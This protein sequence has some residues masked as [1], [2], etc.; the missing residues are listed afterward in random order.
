MKTLYCKIHIFN[1]NESGGL[2]N[3][4]IY[5]AHNQFVL[6]D[7]Q[8]ENAIGVIELPRYE[9]GRILNG[10]GKKFS[11]NT[12]N[13]GRFHT[14]W[15]NMM[16]PRLYLSRNLLTDDGFIYLSIDDNEVNNLR[17]ICDEVFGEENFRGDIIRATGT[18]T[19]QD[20]KKIG[21]SYDHCL[22]YSKSQNGQL[23]GLPLVGKDLNRFSNDEN[24][25]KGKYALLQLRKT[26]NADRKE[27]RENM[28][29][30]VIAPDGTKVF[31]IGPSD[32]LSRWRVGPKTYE[33]FLKEKLIVWKQISNEESDEDFDDD[34][35]EMEVEEQENPEQ[36]NGA[37]TDNIDISEYKTNWRPYVKY[38]LSGRTKQIS[39][40]WSDLDGNKKG[41]IEL[42]TLFDKK[43]IFENP[44]PTDFI[45]RII[46]VS[47]SGS[48]LIIDYFAGS[49]TTAHAVLELN[50]QDVFAIKFILV[51]LPEPTYDVVKGK[52]VPKK[53]SEQAFKLGYRTISDIGKE[54]IRRVIKK[55][56]KEQTK[57]LNLNQTA[58]QDCGFKVLKL[59]KSNFKQ[60]ERLAPSTPTGQI[61]KQLQ[62]H[63]DHINPKATPEDLLYEILIK[64]GFTP[65]EKVETKRISGKNVF[66]VADGALLICLEDTVTKELVNAVAKEQ[67]MQ[68]I[69]L[70][71]A[72]HGNDQLKANA[73]QTFAALNIQ[74]EKHNQIVFRTI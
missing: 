53:G 67:P 72:F 2:R 48:D 74:K 18:T 27:D 19:G 42:K 8:R 44:K 38:Y 56:N 59:D 22:C 57:Q 28:F 24:D 60:W 16:Y 1:E 49:C 25:G 12:A 52:E 13:E 34:G 73:V 61:S 36:G 43:K 46:Q 68:F 26:G 20:G 33:L 5:E 32:Y 45:K 39:N 41:S 51:Q 47:C 4:Y 10:E 69:C 15:L 17:K 71:S 64:A 7:T 3:Y 40:L 21:S 58:K 54:R 29:Y 50:K 31:P 70:D 62:M 30:P 65:T 23:K 6:S 9:Y 66:S 11:T 55:L 63:I 14:K 37:I 35:E